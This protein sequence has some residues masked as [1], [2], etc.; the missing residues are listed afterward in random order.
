MTEPT[1]PASPSPWSREAGIAAAAAPAPPSAWAPPTSAAPPP[2]SAATAAPATVWPPHANAPA[3][4]KGR[5][6]AVA[7]GAGAAALLIG[8]VAFVATRD[9]EKATSV[10]PFPTTQL[11]PSTIAPPLDSI[12]VEST[13]DRFDVKQD[14]VPGATANGYGGNLIRVCSE[15]PALEGA[16][17]VSNGASLG[18]P[19][20]AADS[21]AMRAASVTGRFETDLEATLWFDRAVAV[22]GG[23]QF[24]HSNN[25]VEKVTSVEPT[26]RPSGMRVVRF[27]W[28]WRGGGL[29][30]V[31]DDVYFLYRR[32]VGVVNCQIAGETIDTTR[33]DAI[34]ESYAK[35]MEAA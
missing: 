32:Y 2:A 14:D 17:S 22:T 9:G 4:K 18:F 5:T 24:T 20:G 7:I 25:A 35:R 23:C 31:G 8:I 12:P 30:E 1:P 26:T 33:C 28:S 29:N 34:V 21:T 10:Q 13:L 15:T 19:I 6:V 11:P 16:S 3:P 27:S